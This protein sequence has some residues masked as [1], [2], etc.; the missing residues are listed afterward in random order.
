MHLR[1]INTFGGAYFIEKHCAEI[2]ICIIKNMKE[3]S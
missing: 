3:H 1:R 2:K